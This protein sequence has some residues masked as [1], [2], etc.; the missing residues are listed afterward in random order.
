MKV[1]IIGLPNVGKSTIFNALT[2]SDIPANNY[3]FCTIEPNMG[4]VE[5]PDQRLQKINSFIHSEKII[6]TIIE[7]VDI[8]GLVKGAS[9]GEGLGNKFLSHIRNVDAIIHVVRG[10]HSDDITHVEGTIDPLRDIQI[11]ETEL[12]L[13]D[14]ET[15]NNKIIKVTKLAKSGDKE[16][17]IELSLLEQVLNEL[18]NQNWIYNIEFNQ[19]EK[20]IMNQWFLL[21]NKPII[22]VCNVDEEQ[23]LSNDT[24]DFV[25]LK[26]YANN[27]NTPLL[28]LSGDIEMQ[29]SKMESKNEK[30][31]FLTLYNLKDTGLNSLISTAYNKLGL[32]TFFT[33]GPKEIRAWT[34]KKNTLAPQAAGVI[35]T[36]FERGFIKAEIYNI[37]DL[38]QYKSENIL[39]ENGKI[40][41]EGKKYIMQDGDIVLFRFNV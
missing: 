10:F 11:I 7:F 34:I 37:A 16:A 31:E 3:P 38:L 24:S 29:I 2:A 41:Q 40:R 32:I 14:I 8:A 28:K 33:A 17:K 21:T 1:G 20:N 13:R 5:V 4:I 35:H 26:N 6:N 23:L 15:I 19:E 22:Y 9:S 36:D 30:K 39:K 12:I 27:N 25:K 18:N